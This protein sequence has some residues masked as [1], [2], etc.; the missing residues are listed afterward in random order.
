MNGTIPALSFFPTGPV[1]PPPGTLYVVATPIGNLEDITLRALRVLEN[2]VVLIAVEDTRRTAKLLN[3]YGIHT[4]TTSLHEHNETRKGPGILRRLARGDSVAL[5]SDAGTP[6]LSDPGGQL[7]HNAVARGIPVKALPGPS[8]LLAGLVMSGLADGPFTFIGFP[9]S[10]SKARQLWF[11]SV[12]EEPRPTVIF[13]APHRILAT[14]KDMVTVFGDRE[15]SVCREVTKIHEELVKGPIKDVL[16][17]IQNPRGEYTIVLSAADV[18]H[19]RSDQPTKEQI[20]NEFCH[21]T[22]DKG[23]SRRYAIREIAQNH[24]IKSRDVYSAVESHKGK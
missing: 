19:D 20:W 22:K 9:P 1:A 23:L 6:L 7:V 21:L 24:T 5:V 3:H 12:A 8:A 11:E 13:E 17:R 14:L 4:T 18:S 15:V 2:D 10:R 16:D